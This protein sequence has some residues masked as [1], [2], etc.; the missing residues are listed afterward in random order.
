MQQSYYPIYS[1]FSTVPL[2]YG[3]AHY[4][5]LSRVPS[6]VFLPSDLPCYVKQ[7]AGVIAINP[8]KMTAVAKAAGSFAHVQLHPAKKDDDTVA[9]RV[10]VQVIKI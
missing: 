2:D 7:V 9:S 5:S 6:I 3:H 8:K 1:S 4:A 10:E